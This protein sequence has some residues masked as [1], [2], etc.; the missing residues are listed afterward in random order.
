MNKL[1]EPGKKNHTNNP[2]RLGRIK[3]INVAPVYYDLDKNSSP[4]IELTVEPPSTLNK[5][6]A[7][8]KLDISSVSSA[9]YA[10]NH[11]QWLVIPDLSISS[12]GPVMSVK[13]VSRHALKNLDKKK[14]LLT[15]ESET[16]VDLLKIIIEPYNVNPIFQQKFIASP[17]WIKNDDEAALL[18]GDIALKFPW[19]KFFPYVYD[20]GELWTSQ[21]NL[22]FVYGI[23]AVRSEYASEYP[24]KVQELIEKIHLSKKRGLKQISSIS[25]MASQKL[26][27]DL[28]ICNKYYQRLSYDLTDNHIKG[29]ETFF[30]RLYENDIIKAP[31]KIEVIQSI[32][33]HLTINV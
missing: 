2:I 3:Y 18:I 23:W 14:I 16:A 22:P 1:N 13:L 17:E 19:E 9:A 5:M 29:M 20:L 27:L 7:Q 25:R 8:G 26:N 11:H 10:R 12:Y 32:E 24:E 33:P 21:T 15:S 28:S 30:L 31:F 4:N 6:L